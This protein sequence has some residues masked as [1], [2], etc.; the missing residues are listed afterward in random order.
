[1]LGSQSPLGGGGPTETTTI[2]EEEGELEE[3]KM[4]NYKSSTVSVSSDIKV[5]KNEVE[6]RSI[7][8]S[9]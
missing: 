2:I 1:M 6:V 5:L 9:K 4:V 7:E 3:T 8:G